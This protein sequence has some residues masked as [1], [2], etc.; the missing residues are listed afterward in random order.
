MQRLI[1]LWNDDTVAA[2]DLADEATYNDSPFSSS[3][4]NDSVAPSHLS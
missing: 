4:L 2:C 1:E 3:L